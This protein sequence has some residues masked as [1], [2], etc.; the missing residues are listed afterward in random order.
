MFRFFEL[1]V[2]PYPEATPA[3]PPPTGR[4]TL[5]VHF[6]EVEGPLEPTPE[7]MP[8]SYRRVMVAVPRERASDSNGITR[9]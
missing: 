4:A 1:L 7:R 6:L 3:P 8:E 9:T 2:D 5:G